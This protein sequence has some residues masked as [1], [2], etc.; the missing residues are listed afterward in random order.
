MTK[1]A[2]VVLA[3]SACATEPAATDPD[4]RVA[5]AAAYCD[6]MDRCF[7]TAFANSYGDVAHCAD[8]MVAFLKEPAADSTCAADFDAAACVGK[9]VAPDSCAAFGFVHDPK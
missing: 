4:P 9:I 1:W 6:Y 5:V 3:L 7:A 8:V 2:C